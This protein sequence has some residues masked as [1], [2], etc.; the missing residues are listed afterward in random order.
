MAVSVEFPENWNFR[1]WG[2][3]KNTLPNPEF[4][5]TSFEEL[6]SENSPH[7][8]L[9]TSLSRF[10]KSPSILNGLLELV[11]LYRPNGIKLESE[12]PANDSEISRVYG[13]CVIAG[14]SSTF[15]HLEA[16]GEGYIRHTRYC[17]WPFQPSIWLGCVISGSSLEQ[18]NEALSILE[19]I[20]KP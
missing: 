17:Y 10:E 3:R 5:Q 14:N 9:F 19:S 1:Y 15:L 6:P 13:T 8:V 11:A 12:I 18:F 7:K 20:K 2:N 4:H 16:Q